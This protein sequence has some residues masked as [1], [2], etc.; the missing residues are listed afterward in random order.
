MLE[1]PEKVNRAQQ[2]AEDQGRY[3]EILP[4]LNCPE[5]EIP[6]AEKSRERRQSDHRQRADRY[7][8][9]GHRHFAVHLPHRR[10]IMDTEFVFQR[11]GGIEES[12][13]HESMTDN[14]QKRAGQT[15]II[16]ER[17]AHGNIADL[18]NAG[19]CE[20]FIVDIIAQSLK[21]TVQHAANREHAEKQQKI[22]H[23][24]ALSLKNAIE[25]AN[26]R[27]SRN[28]DHDSCDHRI[29]ALVRVGM[30]RRLP[31]MEGKQRHLDA[32]TNNHTAHCQNHQRTVHPAGKPQGQICH[33]QRAGGR[34]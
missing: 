14:V 29:R 5:R 18:P 31:S 4:F 34:V 23:C 16:A 12:G 1:Q 33:I 22:L 3:K 13:L 19:I 28:L 21:R 6:L 20:N 24:L 2:A 25:E 11:A 32:K 7:G 9:S 27:V 30:R 15:I 26:H 10:S 8:P 17:D